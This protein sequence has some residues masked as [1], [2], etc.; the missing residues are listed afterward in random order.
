RLDR[1]P[2]AQ[3]H[4]LDPHDFCVGLRVVIVPGISDAGAIDSQAVPLAIGGNGLVRGDTEYEQEYSPAHGTPSTRSGSRH[5]LERVQHPQY[6][7]I[8]GVSNPMN[9][10]RIRTI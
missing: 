5:G 1:Y 8:V 9:D 4:D 6:C 3:L 2:G 10:R 7:V